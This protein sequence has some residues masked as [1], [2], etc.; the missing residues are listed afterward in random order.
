MAPRLTYRTKKTYKTRSNQVR[1][2]RTP[3]NKLVFKHIEK[4]AGVPK[5]GD[6][7]LPLRGLPGMRPFDFRAL[8]K[9]QRTVARAYG[10]VKCHK[11]LR[12]NI[13]RALLLHEQR[14][15]KMV[16]REKEKQQR[17]AQLQ[18]RKK[19]GGGAR[20]GGAGARTGAKKK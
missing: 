12:S 13:V 20:A 18:A 11:C 1:P 9:N 15:A 14:S 4:K 8:K 2:A 19:A 17:L 5:C 16:D 6:C 7:K 3:G 10:G